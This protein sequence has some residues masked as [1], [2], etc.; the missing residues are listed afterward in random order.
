MREN[1]FFLP[2][3]EITELKELGQDIKN[4]L[5]K[6]LESGTRKILVFVSS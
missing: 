5:R 2:Q 3:K 1:Y 4:N 6:K